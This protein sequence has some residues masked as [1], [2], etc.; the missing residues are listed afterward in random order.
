MSLPTGP[1]QF[2]IVGVN[3]G[4]AYSINPCLQAQASWAGSGLS[5]YMNLNIPVTSWDPNESN[6]LFQG[7]DATCAATKNLGCEYYDYG[8]NAAIS[9][10][11]DAALYG[12]QV[13]VW[14][15]DVEDPVN[16]WSTNTSNN[17]QIIAGAIAALHNAGDVAAVYST[18]HMWGLITGAYAPG[19][20]TWVA[21]G[22]DP[23]NL[24]AWCGTADGFAG[25]A[26]WMVQFGRGSFDGDYSC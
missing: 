12:I 13:K 19:V 25:G 20:P 5:L 21:T 7:P 22:G 24:A 6:H 11:A 15:L 4:H 26:T 10:M 17:T 8:Y 14:W 2:N 9:S 1:T 3:D 23:S 18:S 16:L